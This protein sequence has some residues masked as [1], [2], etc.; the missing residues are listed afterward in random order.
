VSFP[1][2]LI[3]SAGWYKVYKSDPDSTYVNAIFLGSGEHWGCNNNGDWFSEDDLKRR[4]S[5]FV[6]HAKH[7]K[8]H[9]NDDPMNSYGEVVESF[10]NPDMHRVEGII[11]IINKKS[12]DMIYRVNRGEQVPLSM[13]CKVLHD[14]CS[15]CRHISKTMDDYCDHLKYEMC[16]VY[17]DGRMVYA[18]NPNP[19]FFD[20]SEVSRGADNTA[21]TLRKVASLKKNPTEVPVRSL[22]KSSVLEALA[23]IEKRLDTL[24]SSGEPSI[25]ILNKGVCTKDIPLSKLSSEEIIGSMSKSGI[26][27]RIPSR[28]IYRDLLKEA[29]SIKTVYPYEIPFSNKLDTFI[30]SNSNLTK[31]A[32]ERI[33]SSCYNNTNFKGSNNNFTVDKVAPKDYIKR[34]MLNILSISNNPKL[35]EDNTFMELSVLQN[36]N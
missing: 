26:C 11:K 23:A 22:Q 32:N 12:P 28:T 2:R 21:F 27:L 20:I 30:T 1:T 35:M 5:T 4:H 18:E 33:L 19:T 14:V 10:Y 7:Y 15:I 16:D 6:T 25:K 8:H 29:S 34:A 31:Y 36:F 24:V 17:N 9:A 13:A 3:K